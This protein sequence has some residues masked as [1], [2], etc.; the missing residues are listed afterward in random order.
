MWLNSLFWL[1]FGGHL[2][3]VDVIAAIAVTA[4]ADY[5]FGSIRRSGGRCWSQM[6]PTV[7]H[8]QITRYGSRP[9]PGRR[10]VILRN[11]PL[12]Q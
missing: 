10:I 5:A 12:T 11:H 4:R 9:S 1:S 8:R 2:C 6:S 7:P 3:G